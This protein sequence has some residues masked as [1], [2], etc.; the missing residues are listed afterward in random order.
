MARTTNP[1]FKDM[2]GKLG[3]LVI[4]NYN[5]KTV[6]C[7]YPDYEQKPATGNQAISRLRFKEA[8]AYAKTITQNAELKKKYAK[9]IKGTQTVHQLAMKEYFKKNPLIAWKAVNE[10][11]VDDALARDIQIHKD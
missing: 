8:N 2:S 7:M 10:K 4:K 11:L 9:K 6:V 1:L 5:G 3:N